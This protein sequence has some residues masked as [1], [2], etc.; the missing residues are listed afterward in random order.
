MGLNDRCVEFLANW[1]DELINKM[2]SE[3]FKFICMYYLCAEK[4]GKGVQD[5]EDKIIK[6]IISNK[7]I[8]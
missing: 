4:T 5:M 6:E 3:N 7:N 1:K 8:H 2:D